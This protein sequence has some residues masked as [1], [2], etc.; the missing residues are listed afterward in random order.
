LTIDEFFSTGTDL[1]YLNRIYSVPK[2]NYD[3]VF[4][5]IHGSYS[6]PA[7]FFFHSYELSILS[8]VDHFMNSETINYDYP[9]Y[10]G[11]IISS[12]FIDK[13]NMEYHI[14][15]IDVPDYKGML[16][17]GVGMYD[18]YPDERVMSFSIGDSFRRA[19]KMINKTIY[20]DSTP[21]N[22]GALIELQL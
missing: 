12:Y 2:Y 4:T 14:V 3:F 17:L 11:K 18:I 8:T 10:G 19:K 13:F 6:S 9:A 1:E 20:P 7:I 22:S 21:S 5:D 16:E 15:G